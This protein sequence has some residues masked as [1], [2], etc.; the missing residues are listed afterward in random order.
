MSRNVGI[1][2][3]F[4]FNG[5]HRFFWTSLMNF[6]ITHQFLHYSSWVKTTDNE[7]GKKNDGVIEAVAR[8]VL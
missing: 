5:L 7:E 1:Y 3:K 4:V 6:D 8:C 2:I